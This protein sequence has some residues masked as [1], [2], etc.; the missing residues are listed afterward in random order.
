MYSARYLGHQK[1]RKK[2]F[3][4][5]SSTNGGVEEESNS[6]AKYEVIFNF[7]VLTLPCAR[8]SYSISPKDHYPVLSEGSPVLPAGTHVSRAVSTTTMTNSDRGRPRQRQRSQSQ[9]RHKSNRRD[10]SVGGSL[11][12]GE[13]LR[14]E[15]SN[16]NRD[17]KPVCS[18]GLVPSVINAVLSLPTFRAKVQGLPMPNLDNVVAQPDGAK[19]VLALA[20]VIGI[21]KAKNKERKRD[22]IQAVTDSGTITGQ[23]ADEVLKQILNLF[24]SNAAELAIEYDSFNHI[25]P[26][27]A[28]GNPIRKSYL[29]ASLGSAL[30]PVL[31]TESTNDAGIT[32]ITSVKKVPDEFVVYLDR[33]TGC[34]I[35]ISGP[36]R[37]IVRGKK[38]RLTSVVNSYGG[39]TSVRVL[40]EEGWVKVLDKRTKTG[41]DFPDSAIMWTY[42]L[43]SA[44]PVAAAVC[45]GESGTSN[46]NAQENFLKSVLEDL[47][48]SSDEG[49]ADMDD[50]LAMAS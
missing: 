9:R 40:A 50:A 17:Y 35:E 39:R 22:C 38:Y 14:L 43:E 31:T 3:L 27:S 41:P 2:S 48:E 8:S 4:H 13:A 7:N 24:E 46:P 34:S 47:G 10:Q 12:E 29:S 11:K 28:V 20:A 5:D 26:Y 25:P 6:N 23:K 19:P 49:D 18:A 1:K 21:A 33:K 37:K 42:T 36:E 16:L 44:V 32:I 15:N 45:A 30:E